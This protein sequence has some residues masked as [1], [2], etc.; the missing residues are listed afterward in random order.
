MIAA[1]R[2]VVSAMEETAVIVDLHGFMLRVY[3]SGHT[4]GAI[5]AVGQPVELQ[6]HLL[7]REDALTL[8]GFL[9]TGELELF[10]LLLGV[11]GVGPRVALNLL[12]FV[13][14]PHNLYQAIANE[15]TALLSK[16]PGVGRVT[17]GRI[18][19]DL[20]RKLPEDIPV[21]LGQPD[22]RDRDALAALEALGYTTG[23]A[24]NAL[25]SLDNRSGMTVEERIFGALQ[26]MDRS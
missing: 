17:A 16:A 20:K 10:R 22:D 6:T 23:E 7:V 1:V 4:L 11:T 9:T 3:S 8:Y 21:A 26:R 24:R 2:G 15:D 25:G 5:G 14:E 19:L 12:T 13:G 18:I